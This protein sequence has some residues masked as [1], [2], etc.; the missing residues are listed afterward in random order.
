VVSFTHRPLYT[1]RKGPRYP[2]DRRLGGPQRRSGP[3][4][5]E[6]ILTLDGNR[7]PA[8]QPTAIPTGLSRLYILL[9]L[10]ANCKCKTFHTESVV[11]IVTI[12]FCKISETNEFIH[13]TLILTEKIQC[14]HKR[15]Y[16]DIGYRFHLFSK[17]GDKNTYKISA[18]N[19]KGRNFLLNLVVYRSIILKC[20]L[21]NRSWAGFSCHST[22]SKV[23][24]S[25]KMNL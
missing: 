3:C 7:T 16:A 24:V 21:G 10:F 8:F 4:G 19:L 6:K 18:R 22:G 17:R 13:F 11:Y 20:Y 1:R 5:E 14:F 2:S 12:A 15:N 9:M 25:S 23:F